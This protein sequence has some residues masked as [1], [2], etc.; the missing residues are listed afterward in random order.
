MDNDKKIQKKFSHL[1]YNVVTYAGVMLSVMVAAVEAFL[2]ALDF[3]SKGR[4]LYLG[5]ITYLI[6]PGFLILG[7][8]LIPAGV[9]WKQSRIRR[10]LPTFELRRFRVDLSLSHH[11]NALLVFIIGTALLMLMSLVGAY[12]AFHYTESV[13]FCGVVCH[14][15]MN[16]ERTAY[17]KSPHRKIKCVED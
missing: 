7:L 15:V 17:L 6:L 3:F 13:Q 14:Q 10:G 5:L 1:F 8:I 12:K 16:P 11:R 2:F 4:N 9:L